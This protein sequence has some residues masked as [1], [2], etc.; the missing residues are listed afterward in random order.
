METIAYIGLSECGQ[1]AISEM[2]K[3]LSE[4]ESSFRHKH[5]TPVL[6]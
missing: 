2:V 3:I 1:N 6:Y 4:S 5:Q